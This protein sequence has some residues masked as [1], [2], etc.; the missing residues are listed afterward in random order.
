LACG[1]PAD[2]L[3]LRFDH[4]LVERSRGRFLERERRSVRRGREI[5]AKRSR[6][7]G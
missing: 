5:K 2:I 3:S 4:S 1:Y 6:A 7:R